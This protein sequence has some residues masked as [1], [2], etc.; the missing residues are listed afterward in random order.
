MDKPLLSIC[1]PTYNRANYLEQCLESIVDQ[2]GFDARV[3]IVISDNCS[4]DD[5]RKIGIRYQEK[6][7]NIHYFRN[8]ENVVDM[9]FPLVFRRATGHLRKLTN[10]TVVYR[11]G[12]VQY[13]LKA[14][15][16]NKEKKPQIYFLALGKLHTD[17]Q[18]ISNVEEYIDTIQINLTWIRS[19]AIWD[20]DCDDLSI[21]ASKSDSRLAQ[22][23]YLLEHF[24]RHGRAVIY[25][26]PIMEALPVDGKNLSYGL[27]KVFYTTFLEFIK[28]YLEAGEISR[29][30]FER[31]RKS[32]L[33]EFFCEWIV[34]KERYPNRFIFSD[35][36]LRKLVE[37]EYRGEPYF[38]QYK[39]KL[40]RMRLKAD[41]KRILKR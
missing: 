26:S 22:V 28:P 3:E 41:V 11:P 4:V 14:A 2:E 18:I 34:N 31:L 35:E 17:P 15:E 25:D 40:I 5:T 12:A 38:G 30:C 27:Y 39:R 37:D 36:D 10:D 32:L 29:D 16:E 24:K 20:V 33:L 9:N 19:F 23:P 7:P 13:M 21:L 8:E 1:I 6:Y